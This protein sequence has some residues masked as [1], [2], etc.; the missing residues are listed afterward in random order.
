[1]YHG[2]YQ[3]VL[4]F[5]RDGMYHVGL[6]CQDILMMCTFLIKEEFKFMSCT[7]DMWTPRSN[8]AHI[9]PTCHFIT[10]NF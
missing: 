9:S 4:D 1:M 7:A 5:S 10:P 8:D 2:T 3:I 6:L